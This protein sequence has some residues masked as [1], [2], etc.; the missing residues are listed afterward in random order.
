M[1]LEIFRK[2]GVARHFIAIF[3]VLSSMLGLGACVSPPKLSGAEKAQSDAARAP[4]ASE[5]TPDES[6]VVAPD[7]ATEDEFENDANLPKLELDAKTLEQ[8]L[9]LNLA[10]YQGNWSQAS[11]SA[12]EAANSS[13]DYRVARTATLLA[14]RDN[15]Y[16]T[17][18]K[19]ADLWVALDEGSEDALNMRLVS[20]VGAGQVAAALE[21]LA[22]HR[23]DKEL[24][25]HVKQTAGLLVR[26]RNA[27]A[28]HQIAEHYVKSFPDSAQ[29]MLSMAYTAETF[30][31]LDS[32]EAWVN[33]ALELRP[34][35]DLAAQMKTNMLRRQSKTE[36]RAQFIAEFVKNYPQSTTMRINHAAE[37]ARAKDY[38]AALEVMKQVL[39]TAP[40]NVSALAYAAA[41]AQQLEDTELAKKYYARALHEDPQNDDVRW[42]LAR[43]AVIEKKYEKAEQ[44]FG[45]VTSEENYIAAQIQVANMRYH[46]QGLKYAVNTLRALEPETEAQYVEI[47]LTRHYLLMQEHAYEEALGYINE[48]L[49]YLP[50]NLDLLYARALVASE[51]RRLDIA[52][53]DFRAIIASQPNHANALNA[54]GYTL[55][56]Q[57]NRYEEAEGFISRALELR[58]QDAHILDS[59]GWVAYRMN[60]FKKAIEFL[61]KAFAASPEVEIAA[62]LGEVLWEA[63]QQEK[64]NEIWQGS[65][66]EDDGN[67]VL[68]KTLERYGIDLK[69]NSDKSHAGKTQ[70]FGAL[71]KK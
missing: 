14:L 41:L 36:E 25:R 68:N 35:W 61:E 37:L 71:P 15:D 70:P 11:A 33:K 16:D 21:S 63:G 2:A 26:Q 51:M 7:S 13:Q 18:V 19:G 12:L 29:V 62:H 34:E 56:D 53:D 66:A 59:M 3:I 40:R 30:E 65:Y 57:T 1:K 23:K 24:D 50:S 58:P 32:A 44:L 5:D 39:D 28:A 49:I 48:T 45:D 52:E 67:P 31:R 55:A 47:A 60:D 10:S 27:D 22:A 54:L 6:V 69:A 64:A 38:Q 4:G 42:S 43:I 17:A 9:I 20:Q 8:L 46:T